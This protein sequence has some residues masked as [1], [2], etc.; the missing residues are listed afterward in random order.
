MTTLIGLKPGSK[1]IGRGK[2]PI[3]LEGHF[4]LRRP[5]LARRSMSAAPPKVAV[6]FSQSFE[7]TRWRLRALLRCF[8]VL[9]FPALFTIRHVE[10]I[11]LICLL[12]ALI[13]FVASWSDT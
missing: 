8:Y 5:R 11:I 10:K 9:R 13:I 1:T 6:L 7:A 12:F 4:Q 2:Q 3:S